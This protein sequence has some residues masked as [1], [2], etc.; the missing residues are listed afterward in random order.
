MR[1]VVIYRTKSDTPVRF[2][3]SSRMQYDVVVP[4]GT[5]CKRI[6]AGGTVGKF[7]VDDLSWIDR[8]VEPF[9]HHDATHYGITLESEMV[10]E[11]LT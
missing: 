1:R 2:G 3:A 8:K 9:M 4:K 5:R 6:P 11:V 10:E 7:W